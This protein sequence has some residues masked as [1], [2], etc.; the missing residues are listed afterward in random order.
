[1]SMQTLNLHETLSNA[2]DSIGLNNSDAVTKT[3]CLFYTAVAYLL[4]QN[5]ARQQSTHTLH[6]TEHSDHKSQ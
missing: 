5:A 1:M 2:R 4:E 3:A 6:L